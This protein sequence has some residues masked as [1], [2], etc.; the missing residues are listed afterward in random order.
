MSNK[1]KKK[2]ELLKHNNNIEKI[3]VLS[4]AKGYERYEAQN[5]CC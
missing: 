2:L 5:E 4:S 3:V 1:D